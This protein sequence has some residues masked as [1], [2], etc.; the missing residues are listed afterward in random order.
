MSPQVPETMKAAVVPQSG[1]AIEIKDVRIK[2]P[3]E[4]APGEC[5][6]K[7]VCTGVCHTDL[8]AALGDWPVPPKT[9]L[10]GGHEGVGTIVAIGVSTPHFPNITFTDLGSQAR[11]LPTRP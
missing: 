6:L 9:P 5:L 7:M 4:L 3:E 8:H 11:T 10:I 2:R 1:A